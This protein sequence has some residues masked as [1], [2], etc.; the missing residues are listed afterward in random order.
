VACG[1]SGELAFIGPIAF[2]DPP[3]AEARALVDELKS[4]GVRTVMVTGDSPATAA[5]VARAVGCKDQFAPR[6]KYRVVQ[7]LRILPFMPEC[8]QN[9]SSRW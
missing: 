9:R 3:R 4:L 8:S 7:A 2:G 1:P 6:V 5:T